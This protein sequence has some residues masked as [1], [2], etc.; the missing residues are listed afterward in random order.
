[1]KIGHKVQGH[2]PKGTVIGRLTV[3]DEDADQ[4]HVFSLVSGGKGQFLV[5]NDG[6]V[7]KATDQ[8]LESGRV[9]DIYVE[10]VDDGHPQ[11]KVNYRK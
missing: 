2:A 9:Y 7:T 10:A 4:S 11:L 8:Y 5:N 1:M 6:Q 3:M